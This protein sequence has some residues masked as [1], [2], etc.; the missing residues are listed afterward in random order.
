M[1]THS[2]AVVRD[3]RWEILVALVTKVRDQVWVRGRAINQLGDG[4]R[5]IDKC[6][7]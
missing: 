4:R 1:R 5:D 7:T 2:W 3:V 6:G